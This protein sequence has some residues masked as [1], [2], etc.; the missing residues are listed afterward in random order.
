M[1]NTPIP[2]NYTLR[3]RDQ[4]LDMRIPRIMGIINFTP[5][6]FFEGSRAATV[7]DACR[8]AEQMIGEGA[9]IL[10]IGGY[11]TRPGLLYLEPGA[12]EVAE[13]EEAERV[14]PVIAAICKAFPETPVS[15]DTF[16]SGIAKAALE[17]GASMVND[18][19]AGTADP[20]LLAVASANRAAVV[21]MHMR[22]N[23]ATMGSLTSY[24]DLLKD[25]IFHLRTRCD[26]AVAA[27]VN[28]IVVDPGFGFA[29]TQQQNFEMLRYL[30]AFGILEK[31]VLAGISRKSMIWR[32]L[33]ITPKEALNGTS[34]LHMTALMKG[35]A[36]L[37]VHDVA[38]AREVVR[39][40]MQLYPL[41]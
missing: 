12:G 10:D 32:T 13:S 23:P 2:Y 30:D 21:L 9:D 35:A 3:L 39:L 17:A 34:A 11:S 4:V 26:A 28:E 27:G 36:I 22:G 6:S 1:Q 8:R 24:D 7:L 33:G 31:P 15:I 40:F 14:L 16:R 25:I 29:K 38:P 19:S 41:P 18:I 5:D 37:R 20:D